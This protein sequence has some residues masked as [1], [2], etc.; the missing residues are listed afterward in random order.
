MIVFFFISRLKFPC[1][2]NRITVLLICFQL[3]L[4]AFFDANN[5]VL[6]VEGIE[7]CK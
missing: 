2:Y 7:A 4:Y 6:N 1:L 3:K 5:F